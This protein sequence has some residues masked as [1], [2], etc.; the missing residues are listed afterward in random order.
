[1]TATAALS[2]GGPRLQVRPLTF[3]QAC[4]FVDAHHRH[5]AAP[6]GHKFS[7][8]AVTA[9]GTLVAVAIVGRPVARALDDGLTVEVT[10]LASDGTRNACSAL[11][12]A[13]WRT[14]RAAGYRRAL[15][16]TQGPE[17]GASLRAAGWTKVASLP[18]R[19]GWDAPSRPRTTRGTDNIPRALW[20]ITAASAP[21][22]PDLRDETRNETPA[23][24]P[25]AKRCPC[26]QPLPTPSTGRPPTFCTPAC[27]QRA[28]RQRHRGRKP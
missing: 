28:Y 8:G 23:R 5:H 1:M 20:Q 12:A 9:D 16:Y 18:P 21:P 10:R 14:A 13:A 27:R 3:K 19:P 4:A 22:L 24:M 6:Q 15:T 7:L 11:Y 2:N 26:G 25:R 17:T